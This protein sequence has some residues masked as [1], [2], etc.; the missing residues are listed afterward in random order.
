MS[1]QANTQQILATVSEAAYWAGTDTNTLLPLYDLLVMLWS[2]PSISKL[3]VI[4]HGVTYR[5]TLSGSDIE[6]EVIRRG[7]STVRTITRSGKIHV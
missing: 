6:L 2:H 1:T 3:G 5:V 7:I 4:L